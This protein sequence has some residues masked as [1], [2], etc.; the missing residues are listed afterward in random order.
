MKIFSRRFAL[1]L[2]G[3]CYFAASTSQSV[4]A[5]KPFYEGKT[6]I[7][8]INYAAGG[9]TDVEGRL[10]A[11]H[12]GRHVAGQPNVIVQN[13]SGAGGIIGTNFLGQVAKADGLTMGYFTGAL[14]HQQVKNP[15]LRTDLSKYAFISGIQGVT[16]S[17]IRSDV[18]P[19]IKKP[20][21]LLKAQ[22]FKA[23]GLSN[24]SFKDVAFRLSFDLLGLQYDYVTG[25]NSSADARLAVQR[26][27]V[28]YHDETL[29]AYRSQV[30][31]NM[32]KPGQV[33]ALYHAD[34][35]DADGECRR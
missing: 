3:F 26:N 22:R 19:G 5:E 13:M 11:R 17:Y 15:A 33:T 35:I 7:V 12:L 2:I 18:A 20:G 29:P 28:Q 14:F 9:P 1:S 4:S 34:L 30:E 21:D 31:P 16:V 23:G 27:E 24:D 6:L 32:V 10:L 8:L 25:Y